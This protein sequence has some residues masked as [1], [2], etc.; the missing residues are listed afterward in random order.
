MSLS[1]ASSSARNSFKGKVVGVVTMGSF[2]HVNMDCGFPLAALV[3]SRSAEK[4]GL[5]NGRK[6]YASVKATAVH[7]LKAD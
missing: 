5:E 3:T 6:V 2:S 4:L 1:R 7:V